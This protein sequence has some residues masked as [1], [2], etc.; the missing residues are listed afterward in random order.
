[1]IMNTMTQQISSYQ[2]ILAQR[3]LA[4]GLGVLL[5]A[6][7]LSLW[8]DLPQLYGTDALFPDDLLYLQQDFTIGTQL[9]LFSASMGG[10]KSLSFLYLSLCVLLCFRVGGRYTAA[11]LLLLHLSFFRSLILFTYGFDQL[12]TIALFY[13]ILLP[14]K[15]SLHLLR[16]HLCL[17]YCFAGLDKML[18]I[19]W[20]NGEALYKAITL[21]YGYRQ[22]LPIL[23]W[24]A[25]WPLLYKIGGIAVW[26]SEIM[27]PLFFLLRDRRYALWY[28]VLLH[29]SIACIMQLYLFSGVMLL[30]N[31]AAWPPRKLYFMFYPARFAFHKLIFQK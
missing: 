21:P 27:Y 13:C 15:G 11:L 1:M 25:Q 14:F 16:I 17:I 6:S 20:W 22:L 26:L 8:N 3:I 28:A 18:G 2:A 7:M 4:V 19:T 12:A 29:L 10:V 23:Q 31:F 5:F 24:L 30:L 9:Q